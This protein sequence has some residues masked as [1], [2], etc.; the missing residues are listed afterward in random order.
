MAGPTG[1]SLLFAP[2]SPPPTFTPSP[3][4]LPSWHF[5]G[6]SSVFH[7]R[8]RNAP[9]HRRVESYT[10]P[11]APVLSTERRAHHRRVK[12]SASLSSALSPAPVTP[13][14][15]EKSRSPLSRFSSYPSATM[16]AN[17]PTTP[18]KGILSS[19]PGSKL[20]DSPFS[21]YFTDDGRSAVEAGYNPPSPEAQQ[22][23]LRLN[24]LQSQLMRGADG[25]SER[26]A[27]NI[28]G[29]RLDSI[30]LELNTLHSQ[31]R[32]PPELEDSGL[33]LEEDEDETAKAGEGEESCTPDGL[34][35]QYGGT[36]DDVFKDRPTREQQQAEHD[37]LLV[38]AQ[39]V[40]S[41]VSK[42][43]NRLKQCHAELRQLNEVNAV[44]IEDKDRVIEELKS[45]N[46]AM[47]LDLVH[48]HSELLFLKLQ[49]KALEVE[50]DAL[51]DDAP[52]G[53][54]PTQRKKLQEDMDRWR[55]DWHDV[56]GRMKK[57][58]NRYGVSSPQNRRDSHAEGAKANGE[59]DDWQLKTV[60]RGHGRVQS[61]VVERVTS[62]GRPFDLDGAEK[63]MTEA[64]ATTNGLRVDVPSPPKPGYADHSVQTESVPLS[65]IGDDD[66]AE[67]QDDPPSLDED[68]AI[69]TS[70]EGDETEYDDL[71]LE[72]KAAM[73]IKSAWQD[74]WEGLSN[75]AGMGDERF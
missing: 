51:D 47:Q 30:E 31:T 65:W 24:R 32:M 25:E 67:A 58:R 49:F 28:V 43:Q 37:Y 48:D 18:A 14:A 9:R 69:T 17:D 57:R 62:T 63:Q 70:S 8:E 15:S 41:N 27:L 1:P 54:K 42:A 52:D 16:S 29:K 11:I 19:R 61:I 38:Q 60:T 6:P 39:Q 4:R 5:P 26:E 64:D 53:A 2:P 73:P 12:S 44:D 55:S 13:A 45:Q 68:C 3:D 10:T 59:D 21:D 66:D 20:Q 34:G 75:L 74:L 36:N 72:E 56:D 46:E 7:K 40:L 71:A 35:V 22:M 33:F 50:V 23:L